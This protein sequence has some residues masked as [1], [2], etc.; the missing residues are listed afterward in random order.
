[1]PIKVIHDVPG[2]VPSQD[3]GMS[4]YGGP[5][6][7]Q[8]QKYDQEARLQ[9]GAQDNA[10]QRLMANPKYMEQMNQ[11]AMID[12][13]RQDVAN[14]MYEA[15]DANQINGLLGT[16][17]A[18]N[19]GYLDE[20]QRNQATSAAVARLAGITSNAR[21]PVQ[22]TAMQPPKM[23]PA[24][25]NPQEAWVSN[26]KV[27]KE[28]M[29]AVMKEKMDA[30]ETI[31]REDAWKIAR[32]NFDIDYKMQTGYVDP[33]PQVM[34]ALNPYA[35]AA[36][37]PQQRRDPMLKKD[38]TR[39]APGERGYISFKPKG[40]SVTES[41]A[42]PMYNQSGQFMGDPSLYN[43]QGASNIQQQA[44]PQSGQP[45]SMNREWTSSDGVR[46]FQGDFIG[47]T[48]GVGGEPSAIIRRSSDG[49]VFQVPFSKLSQNDQGFA[50]SAQGNTDTMYD[51]ANSGRSSGTNYFD[52]Q[53]PAYAAMR[54]P[55]QQQVPS[56][57]RFM[58]AYGM[59]GVD[60]GMNQATGNRVTGSVRPGGTMVQYDEPTVVRPP[61]NVSGSAPAA[62]NVMGVNVSPGGT[63]RAAGSYNPPTVTQKAAPKD[64]SKAGVQKKA[65]TAQTGMSQAVADFASKQSSNVQDAIRDAYDT[66][67][68]NKS[69]EN[70]IR[71]L[72]SKGI[73][74][75][76]MM[77]TP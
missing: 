25:R 64:A 74:L 56:Q 37:A 27:A 51:L 58:G 14:G 35:V 44:N 72:L 21:Q 49:Q 76:G 4:K 6:V 31:T 3:E 59:G 66:K 17:S 73:D 62:R 15:A 28:Y 18:A 24:P 19:S 38:G 26:P 5:M 8:Q 34:N 61:I 32:N 75:E 45:M 7:M 23:P 2:I 39:W 70:A 20:S 47:M 52:P 30:G 69:R 63:G 46:K 60:Y 54:A 48:P 29:D 11:R 36:S 67:L 10:M 33:Q 42:A 12:T 1:M 53:N 40:R 55:M 41:G 71:F 57:G 77:P 9:Q 16:M 65:L 43:T 68:S 50:S 22:N 13:I